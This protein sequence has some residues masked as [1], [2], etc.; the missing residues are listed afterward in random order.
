MCLWLIT[1]NQFP[2]R[3]R[4]LRHSQGTANPQ[5]RMHHECTPVSLRSTTSLSLA[6]IVHSP[7]IATVAV[8]H[9]LSSSASVRAHA[10]DRSIHSV[11]PA[12]GY[13]PARY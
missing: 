2:Q 12:P 5:Y 4:T 10:A 7:M 9:S 6:A 13:V 1:R 8:F 3:G 11:Q